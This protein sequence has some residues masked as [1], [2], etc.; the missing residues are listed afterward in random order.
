VDEPRWAA[1]WRTVALDTTAHELIAGPPLTADPGWVKLVLLVK[2][3]EGLPLDGFRQHSLGLH[4]D[5]M[6]A[7]PGLRRYLQCHVR[8]G[9]YG[10]GETVLDAAYQLWFDDEE[11][12]AA[13]LDSPEYKQVEEDLLFFV[14]PK[15][16]HRMVTR[17]YWIIGPEA[18]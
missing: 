10:I 7:V 3:R 13:A 2:R 9:A 5:L 15:Y 18:R 14:E 12:L 6:K 8:D 16:V 17:E 4:A 11:A 1:F